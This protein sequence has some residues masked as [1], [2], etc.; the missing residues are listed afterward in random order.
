VLFVTLCGVL[1]TRKCRLAITEVLYAAKQMAP[2][3]QTFSRKKAQKA[4]NLFCAFCAFLRLFQ[5][6]SLGADV[7]LVPTLKRVDGFV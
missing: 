2:G 5:N 3:T 7:E 1:I 4:Q 6:C